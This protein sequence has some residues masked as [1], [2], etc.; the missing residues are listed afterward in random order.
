MSA[1]TKL[2][3]ASSLAIGTAWELISSPRTGGTGTVLVSDAVVTVS[4][5]Q[6]SL[7]IV[8]TPLSVAIATAAIGITVADKP[9]AVYVPDAAQQVVSND[10]PTTVTL[11]NNTI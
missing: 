1:W 7:A 6:V 9:H 4:D 10:L 11:P 3:A 5:G 8:D 2:L